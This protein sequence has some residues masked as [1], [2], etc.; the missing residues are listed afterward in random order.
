MRS[1]DARSRTSDFSE[2][3]PRATDVRSGPAPGRPESSSRAT[4]V[5]SEDPP[6]HRRTGHARRRYGVGPAGRAVTFATALVTAAALGTAIPVQAQAT[7]QQGQLYAWISDGWGGG[8]VTSEPA[9]I[10]CHQREFKDPY[11]GTEYQEAPTGTCYASFPVGTTVTL[12]AVP[13]PGSFLNWG[14]DPNPVKMYSGYNPVYVW[15]C[16]VDGLCSAGW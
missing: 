13:D 14:P 8:T 5:L 10:N 4:A 2:T 11:G 16:P 7:T 9:G 12:T 1:R 15:F 3:R 6:R